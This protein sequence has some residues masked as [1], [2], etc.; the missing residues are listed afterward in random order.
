MEAIGAVL[1]CTALLMMAWQAFRGRMSTDDFGEG[2][3]ANAW[4]VAPDLKAVVLAGLPAVF[5]S[6]ASVARGHL[7]SHFVPPLSDYDL[8]VW[9][10]TGTG[11][12]RMV[13]V[14]GT[15]RKAPGAPSSPSLGGA[16]TTPISAS[17]AACYWSAAYDPD[18]RRFVYLSF[19]ALHPDDPFEPVDCAHDK[20]EAVTRLADLPPEIRAS[21]QSMSELG[22]YG[23]RI[24]ITDVAGPER[25]PK[26]RFDLAAVAVQ[27]AVVAEEHGGYAYGTEAW[28]FERRDGHWE[29]GLWWSGFAPPNSLQALLHVACTG[30]P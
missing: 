5:E 12:K 24:Q 18:T 28:L 3:D 23:A 30:V 2:H 27:R 22:E 4:S 17:P 1:L 7:R 11:G 6:R 9:G 20:F 16:T 19:D 10:E 15:C 8:D 26:R 25:L 29:G 14:S 13:S 21:L